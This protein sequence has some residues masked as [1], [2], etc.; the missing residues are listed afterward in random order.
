MRSSARGKPDLNVTP[1][2]GSFEG[3]SGG[4][5]S[6]SSSGKGSLDL[7]ALGAER[8]ALVGQLEA[9]RHKMRHAQDEARVVDELGEMVATADGLRSDNERLRAER[10]ARVPREQFD[11]EHNQREAVTRDLKATRER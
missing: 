5:S 7:G 9:A 3:A 8:A 2:W 6:S 10:E 4:S 1:R 11:K